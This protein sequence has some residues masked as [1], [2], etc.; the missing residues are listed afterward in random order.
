MDTPEPFLDNVGRSLRPRREPK[1][2]AY[3]GFEGED[4]EPETPN[5]TDLESPYVM[6]SFLFLFALIFC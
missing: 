2:Y 4:G 1:S 3:E 6:V 5:Q